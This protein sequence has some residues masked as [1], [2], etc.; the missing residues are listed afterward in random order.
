MDQVE[1]TERPDVADEQREVPEAEVKL[2][3]KLGERIR[4]DRLHWG[5][6][7]K[8]MKRNME[9][10][11]IGS[12]K[13]W[14]AAGNYVANLAG[15]HVSQRTSALYAKNPK[16]VAKRKERLDFEVWDENP[17]T[18]MAAI[19]AVQ[20]GMGMGVDP[21]TGQPVAAMDPQFAQ[22]MA[23]VQDFQQGMMWR[24]QIAK[25]GKTLEILFDHSIK[26]QMPVDFKTSMKQLV[27]RV[28][29]CKVGYVELGFQREMDE[30][31][32]VTQHL[33]D[34]RDQLKALQLLAQE[35]A[36][37]DDSDIDEKQLDL[38]TRIA[39]LEKQQYVLVREGLTFDFPR[40]TQVIPDKCCQGLV[41]FI[42]ARW[43]T[44]EYYYTPDEVKRE[45]GVDLKTGYAHYTTA[46]D[47]S[48]GVFEDPEKKGEYACVWKHYDKEAGVVYVMCDGYKG[49]LR[50]P[51]APDV[52][53][54]EFWPVYAL[55][56]NDLEDP[57]DIFP[58]ADV[59]LIEDQQKEYNRSRQGQREHRFAARPRFASAKGTL[60]DEGKGQ[61]HSA[62]PFDV[63]ELNVLSD[64]FDVAK[65][66]QPV[67]V[68]GVDPNLY[69]TGPIFED[70]QLVVGAQ[71][72]QFGGVA[73]ATATES[74]I[75][76]SSRIASV[77]SNVDDLDSFLTRIA[78]AAAQIL[79]QEMNE[80]TV[81]EIAGKGALWP[82]MTLDQIARE[83]YL[84]VEAGSSGKPNQAQE[85]RNW[86]EMLPFVI[87]MPN[88]DP[89]W[90]A[91]ETLRR[92]DDRMDLTEAIT[93]NVPAIVALNR[94]SQP[95]PGDPGAAPDQQGD[96]GADNGP[97][98]PGG[99]TGS[100]A[101]MGNN[102]QPV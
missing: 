28:L 71:E 58:Q 95:M 26:E 51:A 65:I 42:G 15:R 35:V 22:A 79:L 68:P 9:L 19:Q 61:L 72:A 44:V 52:Y 25:I 18:L 85:I 97:A 8:Q 45:F 83:L 99:P 32:Q 31:P 37:G 66:L 100:D 90:L 57:D 69:E 82:M 91:R 14:K 29:T 89:T 75:A 54:E 77:D 62:M 23:V 47:R 38:Q 24:E 101:P 84:D 55:V 41:G 7:F 40:S 78:R 102:Q 86:R 92:L 49:F 81:K 70:L 94:M 98:P 50:P 16:A 11:R 63:V 87:Q 73:K 12:T 10:V 64:N 60:D 74:S 93:E 96:Q 53:V 34:F 17:Q 4:A 88:I 13:E 30:D 80:Q 39:A 46:G 2:V 48:D 5:K 27:R 21:M 76:E 20:V 67:P 43:L 36:E 56:F 1:D 3:S 33:A 6:Q 59:E